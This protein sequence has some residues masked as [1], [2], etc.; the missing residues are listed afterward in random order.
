MVKKQRRKFK[1]GFKKQLVTQIESVKSPLPKPPEPT[2]S[3]PQ[4]SPTEESSFKQE[5]YL[6]VPQT[7]KK[8]LH[9]FRDYPYELKAQ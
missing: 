5:S 8:Y 4:S 1:I 9:F 2:L 6:K 3:A 7:V